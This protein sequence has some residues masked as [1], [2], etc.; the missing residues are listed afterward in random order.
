MFGR[1]EKQHWMEA[2]DEIVAPFLDP[3]PSESVKSVAGELRD[4]LGKVEQQVLAQYTATAAYATLSQ[5]G[6]ETARA[7]ARADLDRSQATV[8]GLID[9]LRTEMNSRIDGMEHRPGL[10]STSLALDAASRLAMLEDRMGSMI[11]ALEAVR[12]G[13]HPAASAGGRAAA[14]E[15]APRRLAG[16]QRRR[17]GAVAALTTRY[18]GGRE[19]H[20]A[21]HPPAFQ[22]RTFAA[23]P[24]PVGVQRRRRP[25]CRRFA[26]HRATPCSFAGP[27]ARPLGLGRVQPR[28][29]DPGADVDVRSGRPRSTT[30]FVA[31]ASSPLR[32]AATRC[33]PAAPTRPGWCSARPTAC[34]AWW[35]TAT[36]TPSCASSP[37][38]A[39]TRGATCWPM[40]WPRC[41][42]W[43][44]S[45]NAATPT[46]ANARVWRPRI[47]LLRGSEPSPD[48]V[49]NEAGVPLR[50]RRGGR[51]QDRLLP[52][53]ARRPLRGGRLATGRRVLNVFSYT[54]AFSVIAAGTR[55]S[56]RHV[57]SIRR[58]RRST[59]P[60]RNGE[61]NGVDVGE[62]MEADAFTALRG[63]RD[64]AQQY[65]LIC[66]DPPKLANNEQ[67]ARQGV[68]RLQGP[69]PARRQAARSRW[70]AA[71]LVVQRRDDA[72]TCSRRW[73]PAP[74]STRS[75]PCAS[76]AACTSRAITRCRW[77]SPRPST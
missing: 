66:L 4:R 59:S 1:N 57:A 14:G 2:D 53:P 74:R 31:A 68:T 77:P 12:E 60:R 19:C 37:P 28:V 72:W 75:A 43:R 64:R 34:P 63:L 67:P 56:Q 10:P 47:G 52:R 25:T 54:G 7:E 65:D 41:P 45:T 23:A 51:P 9:R 15:D 33:W 35:P 17:V 36:A 55:R 29:A 62:L 20:A 48:L 46:Y 3:D 6:V 5:Q 24:A 11:G 42:A 40:R 38:Q 49:A 58:G 69:Q 32:R 21:V 73:S 70:H 16:R 76:S 30:S 39:P 8:I 27:T 13:E 50:R 22:P 61:L 71:D 26:P 44:A 18:G